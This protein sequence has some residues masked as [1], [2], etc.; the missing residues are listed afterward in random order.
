MLAR[1]TSKNADTT[2]PAAWDAVVETDVRRRGRERVDELKQHTRAVA[3]QL[4]CARARGLQRGCALV[5]R[6]GVDVL[7]PRRV[8]DRGDDFVDER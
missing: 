1:P 5:H 3:A 4:I 7:K 6:C 8:V 2:A